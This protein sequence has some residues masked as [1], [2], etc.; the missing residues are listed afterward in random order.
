MNC[1]QIDCLWNDNTRFCRCPFISE[2][3]LSFLDVT[4]KYLAC[5]NFT[6]NESK[7]NGDSGFLL[8]EQFSKNQLTDDLA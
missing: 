7:K 1:N 5:G 4:K 6:T 3:N 8:T 2:V